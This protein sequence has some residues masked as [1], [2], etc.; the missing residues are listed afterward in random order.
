MIR[1]YV[2]YVLGKIVWIDYNG[3]YQELD[4]NWN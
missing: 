2:Y 1:G 3:E 4:Y